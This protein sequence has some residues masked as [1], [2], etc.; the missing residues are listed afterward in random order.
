ME[1]IYIYIYIKSI[2]IIK[3]GMP[4]DQ[5]VKDGER[6]LTVSHSHHK[7]CSLMENNDLSQS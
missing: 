4:G 5:M 7:V 3:Y 6:K 2:Y 1:N